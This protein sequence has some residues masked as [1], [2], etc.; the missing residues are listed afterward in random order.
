MA[1]SDLVMAK[2][3]ERLQKTTKHSQFLIPSSSWE[4]GMKKPPSSRKK[5]T[6]TLQGI[7]SLPLSLLLHLL[8]ST[9]STFLGLLP[10][11]PPSLKVFMFQSKEP[12][13]RDQHFLLD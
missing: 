12:E 11:V 6:E 4:E 8:H 3:S 13:Q 5:N 2:A 1:L 7:G 9:V 10:S